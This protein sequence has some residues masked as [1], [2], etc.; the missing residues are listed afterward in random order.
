M[1]NELC[2]TFVSIVRMPSS[3]SPDIAP[4]KN[5]NALSNLSRHCLSLVENI[6]CHCRT[7]SLALD[8]LLETS[9][10]NLMKFLNEELAAAGASLT[11]RMHLH[12]SAE[13]QLVV[14][15]EDNDAEILCKIISANPLFKQRF[16]ELSRLALLT[17][18]LETSCKA[19]DALHDEAAAVDA[20]LFS[21]YHLCFKGGLS[22]FFI[23]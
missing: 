14:E 1:N 18:G 3:Q 2:N 5:T 20:A 10:E 13:G 17:A 8:D 16:Q 22:H 4:G 6:A 11:G 23:G 7:L 21:R 9:Q 19:Y 12:L 15:S